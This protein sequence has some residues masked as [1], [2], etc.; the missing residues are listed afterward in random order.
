MYKGSTAICSIA[1]GVD[2]QQRRSLFETNK[3]SKFAP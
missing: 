3:G 2:H 1:F